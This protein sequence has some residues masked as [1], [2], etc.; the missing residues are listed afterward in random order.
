MKKVV[1][2]VLV[3]LIWV[4]ICQA[5]NRPRPYSPA[6]TTYTGELV[7]ADGNCTVEIKYICDTSWGEKYYFYWAVIPVNLYQGQANVVVNILDKNPNSMMMPPGSFCSCIFSCVNYQEN[8]VYLMVGDG[9]Y[10]SL[11]TYW[12]NPV[13]YKIDVV[14]TNQIVI[15]PK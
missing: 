2:L 4:A 11:K 10:P 3:T 1:F 14:P 7:D 15:Y 13:C 8:V 9:Y 6:G 12:Y 5:E